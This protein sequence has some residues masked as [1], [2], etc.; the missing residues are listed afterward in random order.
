MEFFIALKTLEIFF[1]GFLQEFSSIC[2]L[3]DLIDCNGL[4]QGG[5]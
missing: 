3:K 1:F 4:L 5:G 2:Y